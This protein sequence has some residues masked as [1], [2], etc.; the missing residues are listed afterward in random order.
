[1]ITS[2]KARK[3]WTDALRS[4]K[5]QQGKSALCEDGRFCC[6]GVA[7]E[8]YQ[9]HVGDLSVVVD[10]NG[11]RNYDDEEYMPPSKVTRWLGIAT[12]GDL[13]TMV[14]GYS[15]LVALNDSASYTF[16]QIADVI[17]NGSVVTFA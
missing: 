4:G 3:L 7:C 16:E 11:M 2:S 12:A 10:N 9:E 17:D 14:S 1:M 6:L 15:S 13:S 8:V 5:Y